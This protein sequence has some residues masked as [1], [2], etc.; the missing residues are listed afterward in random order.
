MITGTETAHLLTR[1]SPMIS[2]ARVPIVQPRDVVVLGLRE[3]QLVRLT[4]EVR[5]EGL[6]LMLQGRAVLVPPGFPLAAGDQLLASVHLQRN[7]AAQLRPVQSG[8][9]PT[10]PGAAADAD[11]AHPPDQTILP[12][13]ERLLWR[14]QGLAALFEMLRPSGIQRSLPPAL[15]AQPEVDRL[16]DQLRRNQPRMAT[17]S[18][19]TLRQAILESGF[20]TEALVA[21]QQTGGARDVKS[22]LREILRYGQ[23]SGN[24][25]PRMLAEAIDDIEAAQ[26]RA[27][28][29]MHNGALV[30]QLALG[31]ADAPPV[32]VTLQRGGSG[33]DA[34][35]NW[36]VDLFS[37]SE[38]WGD[39]WLCARVEAGRR[40]DMTMWAVREDICRL[41]S[42]RTGELTA[43]LG[44]FEL[45]LKGLQIVH[46]SRPEKSNGPDAG[47]SGQVVDLSA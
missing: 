29:S 6:K 28:E 44:P 24:D 20:F 17:L 2:E 41:A 45:E 5:G 1:A 35:S 46:G 36:S 27:T 4:V 9:V 42:E 19:S 23:Q 26:L 3:D 40:L 30:L 7:G 16:V 39:I 43:A 8:T 21:R 47:A 25:A 31:F 10:A 33:A 34:A 15:L 22:L 32:K 12:R 11:E 14:P 13:M 18:G 38:E 37:S